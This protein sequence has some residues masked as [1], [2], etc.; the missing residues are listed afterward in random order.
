[1]KAKMIK[2]ITTQV[3][4]V[5]TL[6]VVVLAQDKPGQKADAPPQPQQV[7]TG[8]EYLG[9][10]ADSIR[11]YRSSADRLRGSLPK[12]ARGKQNRLVRLIPVFGCPP[13]VFRQKVEQAR[14]RDG[15]EPDPVS[16]H[17][18]AEPY[19]RRFSRRS[20][21]ARLFGPNQPARCFSFETARA[22]TG[23]PPHRRRADPGGEVMF[24]EVSYQKSTEA[25]QQER[26]DKSPAEEV[27]HLV[28]TT[29]RTIITAA[30][31][32]RLST[33]SRTSKFE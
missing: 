21:L 6:S 20:G 23:D 3:L 19:N 33:L 14:A 5:L 29:D 4:F 9:P 8:K 12:T 28:L 13:R 1:M 17:R 26:M 24:R 16:Q 2:A 10:T 15:A 30:F 18:V 32:A 7:S 27:R 22:A 11:P 31:Q 25:V